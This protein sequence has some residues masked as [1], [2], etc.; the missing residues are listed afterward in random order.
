[1]MRP[2]TR[3]LL[4]FLVCTASSVVKGNKTVRAITR[5]S[6]LTHHGRETRETRIHVILDHTYYFGISESGTTHCA[7]ELQR[8]YGGA[9]SA[10]RAGGDDDG[11]ISV[12]LQ[13]ASID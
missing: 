8:V 5:V 3:I 4:A 11:H 12:D 9:I 7:S 1:M 10:E 6:C 2:K 13:L